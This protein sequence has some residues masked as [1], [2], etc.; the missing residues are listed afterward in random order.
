[1]VLF[2]DDNGRWISTTIYINS[3]QIVY[4]PTKYN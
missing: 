4:Q 3:W 1:M 2:L